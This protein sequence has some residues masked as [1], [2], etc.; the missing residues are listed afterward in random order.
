MGMLDDVMNQVC[1]YWPPL[2]GNSWG[3]GIYGPPEHIRCRREGTTKLIRSKDGREMVA[4]A[5]YWLP[6]EIDLSGRIAPG[7][8]TDPTPPS[9][10][11]EPQS[12]IETV[13]LD[14]QT[15]HWQVYV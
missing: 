15:D 3:G 9:A 6:R 11:K 7:Q 5:V 8:L 12:T 4:S 1:T 10:A 2:P 14:G 13:G